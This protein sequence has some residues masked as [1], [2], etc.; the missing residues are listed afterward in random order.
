[1]AF[2]G[3]SQNGTILNIVNGNSVFTES[4]SPRDVN[5]SG[6]VAVSGTITAFGSIFA[7]GG[8]LVPLTVQEADGAPINTQTHVLIFPNASVISSGNQCEVIFPSATSGTIVGPLSSTD[9]ALVR[10]DGTAGVVIQDSNAI[11]D[12]DGNLVLVSGLMVGTDAT[13]T[14]DV[15]ATSGVF[16]GDLS[17]VNAQLA[18]DLTADRVL[19]PVVT[20][21]G[22]YEPLSNEQRWV[23]SDGADQVILP[24][25]PAVGQVHLIK[26]VSGTASFNNVTILAS[27]STIDGLA[28]MGLFGNYA[29]LNFVWQGTEWSAF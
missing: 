6:D 29:A 14:G 8:E 7:P 2:S 27:G 21:T 12:D 11:L 3:R 23:M 25:S 15:S 4:I 28:S 17:A 22:L 19:L 1:M 26:D 5:A 10:W 18:G 20:V 16:S 9:N 24:A 13:V